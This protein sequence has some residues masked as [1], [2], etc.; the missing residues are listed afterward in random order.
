M[1]NFKYIL[2]TFVS[3]EQTTY[4]DYIIS[5][6]FQFQEVDAR[7]EYC[8]RFHYHGHKLGISCAANHGSCGCD[9][10]SGS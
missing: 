6:V 8:R 1:F 2:D 3:S 5:R 7:A 10:T 9:N 4:L